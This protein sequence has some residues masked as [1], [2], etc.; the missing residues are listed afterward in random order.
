M[1]SSRKISNQLVHGGGVLERVR[2][3]GVVEAA[4]VGAELLDGLLAG[5]GP[6]VMVCWPPVERG[7]RSVPPAKFWISAAGDQHDRADE[8]D[9]QQDAERAADQVDPEVAELARC[10]LRAK[11]RTSAIATAMPTAADTKF[12]TARP[13]ICTRWPMVDSP[14]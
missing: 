7:R 11:P 1:S 14:E 12:C 2:G 8:R 13:A 3:V 6:P 5:T 4:A 10:L 9:R